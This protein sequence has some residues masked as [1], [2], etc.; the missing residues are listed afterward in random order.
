MLL[1]FQLNHLVGPPRNQLPHA[2]KK[3]L[4]LP[5]HVGGDGSY[6]LEPLG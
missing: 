6:E 1:I 5:A 2:G 3:E 4:A